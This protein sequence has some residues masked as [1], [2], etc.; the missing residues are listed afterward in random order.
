MRRGLHVPSAGHTVLE[1]LVALAIVATLAALAQASHA[2]FVLAAR[3]VEARAALTAVAAAQE[4]HYLRHA[5]YAERLQERPDEY[6][7]GPANGGD[8]GDA[9]DPTTLAFHAPTVTEHYR[10]E[11]AAADADGYRIEARPV[12]TQRRDRDCALF[13]FDA[14]GRRWAADAAGTSATRR[15]WAGT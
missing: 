15:C 7:I 9:D 10:I 2:H 4:R 14:T 6:A 3:R 11:I 1:V 13:V 8:R 5:R 12:G